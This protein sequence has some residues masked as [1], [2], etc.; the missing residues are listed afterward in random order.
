MWS[1]PFCLKIVAIVPHIIGQGQ[2][3]TID[4]KF[5]AYPQVSKQAMTWNILH[6][7][8]KASDWKFKSA[9]D[10]EVRK[11][12]NFEERATEHILVQ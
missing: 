4:I 1:R 2:E 3:T 7:N 11:R 9:K 6:T 5:D 8:F 10:N 12:L